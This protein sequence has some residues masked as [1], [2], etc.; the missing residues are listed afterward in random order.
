MQRGLLSLSV[1]FLPVGSVS[2]AVLG[3][4]RQLSAGAW[5]LS[6][7]YE[8]VQEKELNFTLANDG[9][10]Q[11]KNATMSFPCTGAGNVEGKADGG[12]AM[13]KVTYQPYEALQYY[14]AFGAGDYTLAVSSIA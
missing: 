9:R 12:A 7:F 2:A 11:S 14:A 13:M 5:S 6:A 3:S 8:G 1:F 10:C 4:P